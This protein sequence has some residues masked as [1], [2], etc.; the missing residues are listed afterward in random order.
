M[1]C[2]RR[3]WLRLCLGVLLL[4][5]MAAGEEK[6]KK[7]EA[8]FAGGFSPDARLELKSVNR[9]WLEGDKKTDSIEIIDV[10]TR[11]VLVSVP[12][13]YIGAFE[14]RVTWRADGRCV[15]I[16]NPESRDYH[17]AQFFAPYGK[18]WAEVRLPEF[19]EKIAELCRAGGGARVVIDENA[20]GNKHELEIQWLPHD[21]FF[22]KVD[23]PEFVNP[24]LDVPFVFW[25]YGHVVAGTTKAP[26][27]I[28]LEK[29]DFEPDPVYDRK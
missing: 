21:R 9:E 29:V 10:K 18:S 16:H 25:V 13:R 6:P 11:R 1:F 4:P 15:A 26:P 8:H 2:A 20:E 22:L 12:T 27:H 19:R 28:E 17:Q 5:W 7:N 24:I 14:T 23:Y 3:F